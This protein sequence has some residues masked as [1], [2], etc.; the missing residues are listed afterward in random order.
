[1]RIFCILHLHMSVSS[2]KMWGIRG[3]EG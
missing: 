1:V 2:V 3:C